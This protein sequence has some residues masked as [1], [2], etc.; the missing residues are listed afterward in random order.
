MQKLIHSFQS[1]GMRYVVCR[2]TKVYI[3]YHKNKHS[4]SFTYICITQLYCQPYDS[5]QW[6][7]TR[8]LV[9]DMD[10]YSPIPAF[11]KFAQNCLSM[12]ENWFI[13]RP[14]RN[15]VRKAGLKFCFEYMQAEDLQTNYIDIGPVNKSLNMVAAYHGTSFC[16][17]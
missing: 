7:S 16:D 6:D 8:H 13:F 11:M 5:I 4:S 14:F 1:Y 15:A 12:Y 3:F 10:N 2:C 9:A 17:S